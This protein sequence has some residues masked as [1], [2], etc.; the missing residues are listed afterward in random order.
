MT[1][2]LRIMSCAMLVAVF[3]CNPCTGSPELGVVVRAMGLSA[4]SFAVAGFNS[5]ETSACLLQLDGSQQVQLAIQAMETVRLASE[6]V[7][8][9]ERTFDP[10][11]PQSVNSLNSALAAL[12]AAQ[13]G[14]ENACADILTLAG[15]VAAP[16]QV[17]L[18]AQWRT[19]AALPPKYRAVNWGAAERAA[20][21]RALTEQRVAQSGGQPL[22]QS[23]TEL[24]NEVNAR[25]KIVE[26]EQRL[27]FHTLDIHQVFITHTR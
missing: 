5:Q 3:S 25:P 19:Q 18:L 22:S 16:A 26:A 17:E 15:T 10:L 20:L 21:L 8:E 7:L 1:T 9:A 27:S 2:P 4:R 24:L 13:L 11:D 12:Q 6:H 14:F 23:A